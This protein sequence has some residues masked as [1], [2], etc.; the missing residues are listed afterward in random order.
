MK[1]CHLKETEYYLGGISASIQH[2]RKALDKANIDYTTDPQDD[3]DI[4]HT[5]IASPIAIYHLKKARRNDAKTIVH[6]HTTVEDFKNSFRFSNHLSYPVKKYI[7]YLYSHADLLVC[8]STYN[9]DLINDYGFDNTT[10]ISNGIDTERFNGFKDRRQQAREE[11]GLEQTTCFSVGT[12]IQR[13]G[14]DTFVDIARKLPDL[15]FAWFGNIMRSVMTQRGT[16]EIIEG[17][18]QNAQFTGFI[19]DI[20][21]AFAAGDIF[22]YP[23]RVENQGI[24]ALEAAYCGKPLVLRDIPVFDEYF[25]HGH[26]C[27]KAGDVDEFIEHIKRLKRDDELR[28]RIASNARATAEKHTLDNVGEKLRK[29]YENLI[30]GDIP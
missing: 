16:K 12:A 21:D 8:P 30:D 19:D 4:L 25:E 18:P 26:N 22:L 10:V 24:P 2:Q 17:T 23:T 15:D 6:T 11:Y 7:T 13:K 28:E 27:L 9:E 14:I 3:Y 20:R 29:T 1:V 5:N